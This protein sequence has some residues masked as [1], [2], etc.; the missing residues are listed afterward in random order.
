MLIRMEAAKYASDTRER[1]Y[2]N[3]D[4]DHFVD[5]DTTGCLRSIHFAHVSD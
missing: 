2:Q 1:N 3:L 4:Q 5:L